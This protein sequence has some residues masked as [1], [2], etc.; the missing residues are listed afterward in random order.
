[1]TFSGK[2]DIKEVFDLLMNKPPQFSDISDDE[3]EHN[4]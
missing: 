4:K 3:R 2:L 1:M